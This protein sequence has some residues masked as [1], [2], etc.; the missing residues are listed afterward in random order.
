MSVAVKLSDD[1]VDAAR[2]QSRIDQRSLGAQLSYWAKLG[3]VAEE[4]PD[5]PFSFIHEVMLSHAEA[6]DGQLEPYIFSV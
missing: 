5:L 1:V 6:E 4:N 2:I 3:R